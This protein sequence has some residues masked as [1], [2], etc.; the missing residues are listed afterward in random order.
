MWDIW[1]I[2]TFKE[3]TSSMKQKHSRVGQMNNS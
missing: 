1:Y 3:V 2:R